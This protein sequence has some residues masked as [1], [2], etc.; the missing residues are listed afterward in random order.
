MNFD[1]D[2]PN[3]F[4]CPITH[5]IMNN[6][7]IDNDGNTYEYDAIIQWLNNNN[8]SPIT[9]NYLSI[10]DLKPNRSLLELINSF[11]SSNNLQTN[12][13]TSNIIIENDKFILDDVLF[14]F[15]IDKFIK[16]DFTYFL[17]N[18]S[19]NDTN[20]APPIDIVCVIDVSGSMD[21]Y[22]YVQQDGK[23]INV[24][25]TIL[26]I[27]KHAL[28]TIIESMKSTDRISI[29]TFSN[30]ANILCNFTYINDNNKNY[31]K[32]LVNNLKTDGATNIW[33][34]INKGLDVFYNNYF[35][36]EI[37]SNT[38][39]KSLVL[40]TDGIPSNHLL[41]PRG[42]LE[43]LDRKINIMKDSNIIVPNIYTFGFGN[44]LD[45]KLLIDISKKGNGHFSYIPDSS[46]VGTIFIHYLAYINTLICNQIYLD[47]EFMCV[48][49]QKSVD[50]IGYNDFNLNS[51]HLG[52]N[53]NIIFKI[54][55]SELDKCNNILTFAFKYKTISN[56]NRCIQKTINKNIYHNDN[57]D[58]LDYNIARLNLVSLFNNN[59]K[60]YNFL[61]E[62]YINDNNIPDDISKDLEQINLAINKYYNSWG[63]NYIYSFISALFEERC[64]N[65]KDFSIQKYGGILFKRLKDNFDDIFSNL[66]PPIPSCNIQ[67]D[68]Y[69]TN[70][71]SSISSQQFSQTFN[72]PNAGCFH[73]DSVVIMS[74]Y[75]T[76]KI[77]NLKKNDKIIDKNGNISNILCLIK[78]K[79]YNNKCNM[80]KLKGFKN[81]VLVTP[82]HPVLNIKYPQS[83]G[84]NSY[85]WIFPYSINNNIYEYDTEYV[86]NLV[87]DKNHNFIIDNYIFITLGHNNFT[88]FITSHQYFGKDI[89]D[90]LKNM[91]G[92]DNG[93]II[94][95][96]INI[97]RCRNTNR[98]IKWLQ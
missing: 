2:I 7:F 73:P 51:L 1:L 55:N 71:S 82:F 40:L 22:A 48:N 94:L 9:R 37:E 28:N 85:D 53:R 61:F 89:I 47:F 64:N 68:N 49:F 66:P 33:A 18:I 50:I 77:S 44:N 56:E 10:S 36:S 72:N 8:T 41:P 80:I 25:Y 17:L 70:S 87:L 92:Y 76:K 45:T 75:S 95:D 58:N 4:I 27:T 98:V 54:S 3:S 15:N 96:Q 93:L 67:N 23:T 86:Y 63:K 78:I 91:I 34:G 81:D 88:N 69:N 97:I 35:R 74:D 42:I 43:T 32:N 26:D 60:N 20:V 14:D 19:V 79:C 52:H 30:Y 24:G 62:N 11:K 21:S 65:F 38:R 90:D 29:I 31:I 59:N 16:N 39:I 46:F 6:P 12:N 57:Y 5:N 84:S 83:I 13:N